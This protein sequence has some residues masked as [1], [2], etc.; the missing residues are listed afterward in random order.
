LPVASGQLPGRMTSV[1]ELDG[2]KRRKDLQLL[3]EPPHIHSA[4]ASDRLQTKTKF[5]RNDNWQLATG[6]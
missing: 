2:S 3:E 5:L 1:T 6:H 4:G